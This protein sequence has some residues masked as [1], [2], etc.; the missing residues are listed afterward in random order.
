LGTGNE[1][2]KGSGD[3]NREVKIRCRPDGNGRK[4]RF[5]ELIKNLQTS[6][7]VVE[8]ELMEL[9]ESKAWGK[10]IPRPRG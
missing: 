10:N 5:D 4:E 3:R 8:E 9:V 2:A 6:K 1:S 7:A